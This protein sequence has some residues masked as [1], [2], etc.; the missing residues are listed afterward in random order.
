MSKQGGST[1][2]LPDII[3]KRYILIIV[4]MSIFFIVIFG[5]L[6]QL[7]VLEKEKYDEKLV[8]STEK[9]ID[10]PS[11]PRGRI[12]DRNYNLI[13]DNKAVKTIYYKKA[14]GI[15]T[16]DE[17]KLAYEVSSFLNLDYSKLSDKMLKTF[18]YKIIL[19]Q[20]KRK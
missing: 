11:S 20:L 3:E 1:K 15:T 19:K 16:K 9:I 18:W 7:Q 13:V 2:Y 6:F 14:D 4:I 8:E 12:Y 17:I 10:G 5:R